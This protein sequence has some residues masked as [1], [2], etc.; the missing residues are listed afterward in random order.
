[1]KSP[2]FSGNQPKKAVNSSTVYI[3]TSNNELQ[4][5]QNQFLTLDK[6]EII[7][8]ALESKFCQR[9]KA[10]GIPVVSWLEFFLECAR[11]P[12]ESSLQWGATKLQEMTGIEISRQSVCQR[13]S[14]H[15]E[16]FLK[17]LLELSLSKMLPGERKD[18]LY[19]YTAIE[20]KD[21]TGFQLPKNFSEEYDG[22]KGSDTG[23]ALKIQCSWDI[24]SKECN[25]EVVPGVASDSSYAI[26]KII[27]PGALYLQ[28]LGYWKKEKF[29]AFA[30]H[31]A[32]FISRLKSG[33]PVYRN[34]E[35]KEPI[36]MVQEINELLKSG[37]THVEM[38]VYIG[39]NTK[40]FPVRLVL[41]PVPEQVAEQRIRERRRK[42]GKKC[43]MS[44]TALSFCRV[45]AVITNTDIPAEEIWNVYRLRWSIEMLFKAWKSYFEIDEIKNVKQHR[46][47][48]ILYAKLLLI[49]WSQ[50][51]VFQ[52]ISRIERTTNLRISFLG[53][54]KSFKEHFL[55]K[56]IP[57]IV[58]RQNPK[59]LDKLLDEL[60]I[61][62]KKC[63]IY[64][65]KKNASNK[66][67]LM[68]IID[69]LKISNSF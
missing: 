63:N 44:A 35:D 67:C 53:A 59:K 17:M 33:T 23:K 29:L 41:Y 30:E 60:V 21:S 65:P 18:I 52:A 49:L 66:P 28:D 16:A 1:M 36:N 68:D 57:L 11:R 2:N 50:F 31:N 32:F 39:I 48:T 56:L 9:N 8:C 22:Y 69:S 3:E 14:E 27:K 61:H 62:L 20:V 10:G 5:Q 45:T 34:A 51:A 7:C 26:P 37:K 15:S 19:K 42:K 13:F 25:I 24:L 58:A 55:K 4:E 64:Q 43:N 12:K 46:F 54:L 47:L 40:R 6:N 38:A